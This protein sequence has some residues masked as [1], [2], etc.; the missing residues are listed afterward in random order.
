MS[1]TSNFVVQ[2]F[3]MHIKVKRCILTGRILHIIKIK[4]INFI[5][6]SIP[7]HIDQW[8]E[9]AKMIICHG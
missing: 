8:P 1:Q 4:R 2:S 3:D 5:F 9:V 6:A 7:V